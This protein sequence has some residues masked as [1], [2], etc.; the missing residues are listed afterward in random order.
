[1]HFLDVKCPFWSNLI[2]NS[3]HYKWIGY[4]E[5]RYVNPNIDMSSA[6]LLELL[7][8]NYNVEDLTRTHLNKDQLK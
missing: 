5:P 2:E 3:R 8:L 7:S 4:L 6:W 1:M